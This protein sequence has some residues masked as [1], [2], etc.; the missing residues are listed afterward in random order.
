MAKEDKF[1][2]E[3]LTEDK[4]DGVAGGFISCSRR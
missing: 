2:D 3:M 1:A 4:L